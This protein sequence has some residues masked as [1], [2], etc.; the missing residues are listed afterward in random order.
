[1]KATEQSE[2]NFPVDCLLYY[3]RVVLNFESVGEIL[4]RG[5]SNESYAVRPGLVRSTRWF[6][7]L[8][9]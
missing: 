3:T 8:N 6:Q 1:M 2:Q 9:L 4:E 5:H 7:L